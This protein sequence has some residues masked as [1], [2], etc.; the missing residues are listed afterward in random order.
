[1]AANQTCFVTGKTLTTPYTLGGKIVLPLE[2]TTY[3][4][5]IIRTSKHSVHQQIKKDLDQ[6]ADKLRVLE[7]K[8]LF[9]PRSSLDYLE[10][11]SQDAYVDISLEMQGHE[12]R[13]NEL[14]TQL[15]DCSTM[16]LRAMRDEYK[17]TGKISS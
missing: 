15:V 12:N 4:H 3:A 17:K 6:V 16:I 13:A 7:T 5:F 10:N 9:C 1:M 8:H 11:L 14:M 2:Q